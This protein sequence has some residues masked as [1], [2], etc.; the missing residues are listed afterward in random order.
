M[1]RARTHTH[2]H[3]HIV[4]KFIT[5]G[6]TNWNTQTT[7]HNLYTEKLI[8]RVVGEQAGIGENSHRSVGGANERGY[9]SRQDIQDRQM[10]RVCVYS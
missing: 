8:V 9:P 10:P 6:Y 5:L 7:T 2:K 3:T 4:L 1:A